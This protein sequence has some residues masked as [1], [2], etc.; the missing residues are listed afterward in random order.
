MIAQLTGQLLHKAPTHVIIDVGGV[1]YEV[2]I[3]LHTFHKV[4]QCVYATELLTD[5]L[6]HFE[7]RH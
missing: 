1:G 5:R 2:R 3:S 4:I 6:T 7:Y